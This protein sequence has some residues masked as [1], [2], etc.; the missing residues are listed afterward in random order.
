[1]SDIRIGV[2]GGTKLDECHADEP[3]TAREEA[4]KEEEEETGK[5][6]GRDAFKVHS[7]K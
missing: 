2:P 6:L 1:M 3:A 5:R 7:S 4:S